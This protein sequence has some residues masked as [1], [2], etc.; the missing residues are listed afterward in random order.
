MTNFNQRAQNETD[1]LRPPFRHD[2]NSLSVDRRGSCSPFHFFAREPPQRSPPQR[3]PAAARRRLRARASPQALSRAWGCQAAARLA[4]APVPSPG[5][6]GRR[7]A[8][9][10]LVAHPARTTRG[11]PPGG[12]LETW[13][14]RLERPGAGALGQRGEL[15]RGSAGIGALA[16]GWSARA[17]RE[18]EQERER[19][20]RAAPGAG[21]RAPRA[22]GTGAPSSA[23]SWNARAARARG[24]GSA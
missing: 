2:S 12:E 10:R 14:A 7:P 17:A 21:A 16:G 9:R 4:E 5:P 24:N 18:R 23:G 3:S 6:A 1:W 11:T 22:A 15:K 8:G 13:R 20:R 19:E